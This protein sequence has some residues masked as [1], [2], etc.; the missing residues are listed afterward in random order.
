MIQNKLFVGIA[1]VLIFGM[2]CI[3]TVTETEKA[4]KFRLGEIVRD[5]YTPGLYFK[6]PFI[7]NVKKFDKRIQTMDTS[8]E[9]FLTAEKKNVIVDSFVKWRIGDIR[10]FY[11]VV[12]GDVNQANLRLD[13]IIKDAFRSEFGKRDI[14]QL[15]STDRSDI[16]E[17][18]I[19]KTKLAAADLGLDILDVQ[20]KRIDL[21]SEVS[22]SV[23]R[24]ME[25]ERER[26][27]REFRSQGAEAAER[28][29]ADAD[30]QRVVILA[31]AFRDAEKLRGEGDAKATEI[32]AKAYSSDVE[33]YAF[34]RSLNAYRE[35]F[36]KPEQMMVI[37]PD[38][39]FF[40]YFKS[41]K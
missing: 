22:S 23:Y 38:S 5:D 16:R 20:V 29:R 19:K 15:V 35:T 8:P 2:M 39:D 18:L 37:D 7:N 6:W 13:Q 12:A 26:V 31:D 30:R 33:F 4:I 1:A 9:R 41:Q 21:P 3:F 27:A 17:I 34:Y 28:I 36:D 32:Y 25:A 10:K 40:K 14:K 24:R 11:T